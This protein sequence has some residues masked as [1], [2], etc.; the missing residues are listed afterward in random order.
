MFIFW[1]LKKKGEKKRFFPKKYLDF[2]KIFSIL[3]YGFFFLSAAAD[4]SVE[5]P[6]LLFAHLC[7]Q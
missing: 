1:V 7:T 3:L 4:V 5:L 6:S 2:L